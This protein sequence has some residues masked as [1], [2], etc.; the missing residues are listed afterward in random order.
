MKKI[1]NT[2]LIFLCL[3][4]FQI[5]NSFCQDTQKEKP[6]KETTKNDMDDED[7]N[8]K[9]ATSDKQESSPKKKK[10]TKYEAPVA[11]GIEAGLNVS[12]LIEGGGSGYGLKAGGMVGVLVDIRI[13]GGLYIQPGLLYAMNGGSKFVD[14]GYTYNN[15]KININT[16]DL[17]I[18]IMYK[19]GHST[20][21]FLGASAYL[22]YNFSGT[23]TNHYD[24]SGSLKI[25]SANTDDIKALDLGLGA[26]LGFELKDGLFF[27]IK[28][29]EG[30]SNLSNAA[31]G[32]IKTSSFSIQM[33]FLFGKKVTHKRVRAKDDDYLERK[34]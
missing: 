30:I 7:E 4:V 8:S 27:S 16:L 26:I 1:L 25:G 14:G 9:D 19:F 23:Y 17:P 18:N 33:G 3:S 15:S 12:D 2:S 5:P 13:A 6:K 34:M 11:F 20:R 22:G 32:T 28:D 29:R 10:T 24:N 21:F 31:G